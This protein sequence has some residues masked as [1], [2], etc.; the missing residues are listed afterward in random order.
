M[1]RG[2]GWPLSDALGGAGAAPIHLQQQGCRDAAA[3]SASLS[4][5]PHS[6]APPMKIRVV[7]VHRG[8][9]H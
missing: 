3:Q 5:E 6:A 9:A 4:A 1:V 2:R 8:Q 7:G